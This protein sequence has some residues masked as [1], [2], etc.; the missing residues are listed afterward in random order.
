MP[1]RV[2]GLK[3]IPYFIPAALLCSKI[4]FYELGKKIIYKWHLCRSL[5]VLRTI[6]LF[7]TYF[8]KCLNYK[9][10]T[11]LRGENSIHFTFF[12]II[13]VIEY[14][15]ILRQAICKYEEWILVAYCYIP[16]FTTCTELLPG[17]V[18]RETDMPFVA[19]THSKKR[20][21]TIDNL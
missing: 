21:R 5:I 4:T 6:K 8:K 1:G 9:H 14:V 7:L 10:F 19:Y 17:L 16:Q 13:P 11:F 15:F 3:I 18:I 2:F 20:R 12:L